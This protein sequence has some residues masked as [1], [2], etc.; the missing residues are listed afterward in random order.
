MPL[1]LPSTASSLLL[2]FTLSIEEYGVPAALGTRSGVEVLTTGIEQRLADWPIDMPGA[3]GLSVILV[4]IACCAYCVQ[5]AL[6]AGKDVETTSGKPIA[7]VPKP[8]GRARFLVLAL[9]SLVAL[10][11]VGLPLASIF[12]TAFSRTLSGGLA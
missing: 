10:T 9:F 3:A 2:A 8:L 1:A 4:A 6:V 12:V 5:R 7:V 11:A